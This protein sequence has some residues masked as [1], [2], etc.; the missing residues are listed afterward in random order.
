MACWG[1]Q[2]QKEEGVAAKQWVWRNSN[3]ETEFRLQT[4]KPRKD[5]KQSQHVVLYGS[6][7]VRS[8]YEVRQLLLVITIFFH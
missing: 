2:R 4:E 7:L 1:K 3:T 6:E 5:K 8:S